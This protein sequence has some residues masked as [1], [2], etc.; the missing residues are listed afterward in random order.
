M[1]ETGM[2]SNEFQI[3]VPN[4]AATNAEPRLA[5]A[6]VNSPTS[7][8]APSVVDEQAGGADGIRSAS[9]LI[10]DDE[11]LV[12]RVIK[13]HLAADGFRNFLTL[14]DSRSAVELIRAEKPD[15][16]L[17]DIMMPNV[18]GLDLLRIRQG[19]GQLKRI[20]F[21]ILSANSEKPVKREALSLGATEFLAKPVDA[22]D[23]VLRVKNSLRASQSQNHLHDYAVD[24]EKQVFQRTGQ[25]AHS[26][27]Q[28]IHCLARAA[29]FRD[30]ET[31]AHVIRVGKFAAA[32]AKELGFN[33]N[34]CRQLELAAQ[35]HDVGKIGIPDSIL[36]NPG[37][38][39]REQ[40][41]IMKQH[42]LL[43]C[44]I[45]EP[46]AQS[47]EGA[48]RKNTRGQ[49]MTSVESPLLGLAANIARTHHEKWD[50]TGYPDGLKGEEIPIEGRIT[51]VADVYDALCSER[52]YKPKFPRE[53]CLEIMLS[54]RT[55]RFDPRV[56][57]VF[58]DQLDL[59][60]R[61]EREH[62]DPVRDPA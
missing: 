18:S 27:E 28:I 43:G 59:I 46:I 23:L 53:K 16:V 30:N 40:F 3:C 14:S 29:E 31:G 1:P 25:I 7:A 38:L 48:L 19:D 13:R 39:S 9:I 24:L 15:I 50:G 32:I 51:S 17:L 36:L 35:L 49:F 42:C 12:L 54:E 60:D 52:P 61:I 45:I 20:P 37:K 57:D 41:D 5:A 22:V 4:A 11:P 33:A 44:Q 2:Q 55:T 58:F 6:I 47:G 26:R 8:E 62:A 56:L 21:L 34:Y 10:I